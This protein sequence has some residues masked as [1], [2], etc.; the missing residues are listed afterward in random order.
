MKEYLKIKSSVHYGILNELTTIYHGD[1]S[2]QLKG[3][4]SY[5]LLEILFPILDGTKTLED[6]V[7]IFGPERRIV[8]QNLLSQLV[9]KNMIQV[10]KKV[11]WEAATCAAERN[12]LDYLSDHYDNPND[13]LYSIKNARAYLI[14]KNNL[15]KSIRESLSHYQIEITEFGDMHEFEQVVSNERVRDNSI[16]IYSFEKMDNYLIEYI[17]N[18]CKKIGI[19]LATV[20]I[21]GNYTVIGPIQYA[22]SPCL[23]C[24]IQRNIE[25]KHKQSLLE[26]TIE[27][28]VS[29]LHLSLAGAY[30]AFQI[31]RF[32]ASDNGHLDYKCELI[33]NAVILNTETLE[34]EVVPVE[35]HPKCKVGH[36]ASSDSLLKTEY[37]KVINW[38]R[39]PYVGLVVEPDAQTMVQLPLR[40]HKLH[41]LK[42]SKIVVGCGEKID[43]A[44]EAA[45]LQ[46]IEM[47]L[48]S[49]HSKL[50]R[51]NINAADEKSIIVDRDNESVLNKIC[52]YLGE[53]LFLTSVLQKEKIQTLDVDFLL[54]GEWSRLMKIISVGFCHSV[55]IVGYRRLGEHFFTVGT[56][57]NQKDKNKSNNE[58]QFRDK[59]FVGSGTTL[60]EAMFKSLLHGTASLQ[61]LYQNKSNSEIVI[62]LSAEW[63]K[64]KTEENF[65]QILTDLNKMGYKVHLNQF[66]DFAIGWI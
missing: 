3:I 32:I 20:G 9:K 36:S 58:S 63:G 6:L 16:V 35:I 24:L 66:K 33:E 54:S 53:K 44:K 43:S 10:L 18:Y 29:P 31:I 62:N 19:T 30:L 12:L 13:R 22:D 38:I 39:N 56:R 34:L 11:S 55:E 45:Y 27:F 4:H 5:K 37:D 40:L 59:I 17:S 46:T 61:A 65:E 49:D 2:I 21:C 48:Q 14:G 50:K 41:Y 52:N 51:L 8:I 64:P 28:D 47:D 7:N 42:S 57:L 23:S 26:R 60:E 1:Q 15:S 25:V